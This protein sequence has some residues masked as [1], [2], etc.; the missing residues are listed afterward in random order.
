MVI[1]VDKLKSSSG[2]RP[3]VVSTFF[4]PFSLSPLRSLFLLFPTSA[5]LTPVLYRDHGLTPT[6]HDAGTR[7][8]ASQIRVA[9]PN[10]D[11]G[12]FSSLTTKETME[13]I[14][15]VGNIDEISPRFKHTEQQHEVASDNLRV[16]L[17]DTQRSQIFPETQLR[18]PAF[19]VLATM[20]NTAQE[21]IA[22]CFFKKL[23]ENQEYKYD[24][25]SYEGVVVVRRAGTAKLY[26]CFF[27]RL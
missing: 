9:D 6:S 18:H 13:W 11:N 10:V 4:S 21:R 2:F 23:L 27:E 17:W 20:E 14:M 19:G 1:Q 7:V 12:S 22:Q 24:S 16:A 26:Y 8:F 15:A 25:E 3:N 5:P